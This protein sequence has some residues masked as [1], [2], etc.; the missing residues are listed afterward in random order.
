MQLTLSPMVG[1]VPT[2]VLPPDCG[3]RGSEEVATE[4][5]TA[6]LPLPFRLVFTGGRL[7]MWAVM[8]LPDAAVGGAMPGAAAAGA[9]PCTQMRPCHVMQ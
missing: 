3:V 9:S 7:F 1:G 8:E 2:G 5:A 6:G 4:E